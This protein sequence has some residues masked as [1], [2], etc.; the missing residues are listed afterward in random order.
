MHWRL[1][2]RL[3]SVPRWRPVDLIC[4]ISPVDLV[5]CSSYATPEISP[6]F[7]PSLK[8]RDSFVHVLTSQSPGE[9]PHPSGSVLVPTLKE[10]K[11]YLDPP[12]VWGQF[13]LF[14]LCTT[15]NALFPPHGTQ[16]ASSTICLDWIWKFRGGGFILFHIFSTTFWK[17]TKWGLHLNWYGTK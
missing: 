9:T 16:S 1:I 10:E 4:S 11:A 2:S 15:E 3:W 12:C 6:L 14:E 7:Q 13:G 5:S 8:C 17:E